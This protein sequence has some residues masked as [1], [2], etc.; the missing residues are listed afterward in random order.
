MIVRIIAYKQMKANEVNEQ[1]P[2]DWTLMERVSI[3]AELRPEAKCQFHWFVCQTPGLYIR[4]DF[5][6]KKR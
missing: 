6:P 5:E 4:L 1:K 2:M 3:G